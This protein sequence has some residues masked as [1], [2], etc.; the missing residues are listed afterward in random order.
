[1]SSRTHRTGWVYTTAVSWRVVV[2]RFSFAFLL[3][4][5]LGLLIVGQS[6]PVLIET[7]RVRAIDGIAPVL[8]VLSRPMAMVDSF[9]GRIHAYR[10]LLKENAR[11]RTENA[12]L[13]KWQNAVLTL[14]NENKE[15][16]SLLRYKV[17]PSLAYISARV[18]A[19]TGGVFVHSL[20]VTAGLLDGVRE[21]MAAMTGDGLVGRIVEAGEWTSRV[22]LITDLNSRIPVMVMG[23]GEHAI[24]AGNN[25]PRP[26]MLYLSQEAR[27]KVGER[28][29]TSGHG[30]VFPPHIPVGIV[31]SVEQGAIEVTP[32]TA[33]G[34]INQI[35]L[36]DFDLA[37]GAVNLMASEVKASENR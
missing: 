7:F 35:R 26:K 6:K 30:G 24:L 31:S 27:V 11:L 13:M 18:I 16:R 22:L 3:S 23:S 1:M 5:S 10:G 33:L 19:D 8:D 20:V 21:G 34:R 29:M 12:N 9:S 2:Q 25:S 15:L 28:V 14:D 37:G 36:I 17:E 4:L 32:I